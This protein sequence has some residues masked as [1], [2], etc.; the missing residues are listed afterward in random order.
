MRQSTLLCMNTFTPHLVTTEASRVRWADLAGRP[1]GDI[2]ASGRSFVFLHGLT[3]DHRMWDPVL[4][5]LPANHP[6]VALDLPGHGGSPS[7]PR[8]NL[9]AV[10]DA[11]HEAVRDAG[12]V[13]PIV[14]GHSIGGPIA[15]IYAIKYP[16]AAIVTVDQPVP[17]EPFAHLIRSLEGELAPDSFPQTWEMF[18][19]SMH[20]ERVPASTR[21]LLEVGEAA[22][23]EQVLS[24]WAELLERTPEDLALWVD[25]QLAEA[26]AAALPYLA[27]RGHDVDPG[28]RAF[29]DDRLPHAEIVVWP[30]G[31]HFPHLADPPR[32]ATMLT[33]LAAG[34]PGVAP[35]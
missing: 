5:A 35:R 32:F 28:E 13:A 24:Y 31:H 26:R 9:E 12:L 23:R 34:L 25:G 27:L 22:T 6:A 2:D 18:R 14:V 1:H 33:G 17:V 3:F 7:L 8:H 10:A 4:D 16:S 21:P 19:A 15:S 29:L 30:V 11:I 20:I